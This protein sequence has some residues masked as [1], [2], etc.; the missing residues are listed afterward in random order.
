MGGILN[1]WA[2]P[3]LYWLVV[4]S[5]YIPRRKESLATILD[6]MRESIHAPHLQ[7]LVPPRYEEQ[8]DALEVSAVLIGFFASVSR[9]NSRIH[10]FKRNP[11]IFFDLYLTLNTWYCLWSEMSDNRQTDR[12]TDRK[13]EGHTTTTVTHAAHACWGLITIIICMNLLCQWPYLFLLCIAN[14]EYD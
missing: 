5:S 8:A 4:S 1:R 13:I 9:R 10:Q 11:H 2:G 14:C 3:S 7:L 6:N 12:Q